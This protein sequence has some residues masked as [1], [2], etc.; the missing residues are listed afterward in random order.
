MI[1]LV[2]LE[3]VDSCARNGTKPY[4]EAYLS[5]KIQTKPSLIPRLQINT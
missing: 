3:S 2:L 4:P 5:F 1:F